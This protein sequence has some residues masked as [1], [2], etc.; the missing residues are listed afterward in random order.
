MK[1]LKGKEYW[2]VNATKE[3]DLMNGGKVT[4]ENV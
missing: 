3:N 4:C 1:T 2:N